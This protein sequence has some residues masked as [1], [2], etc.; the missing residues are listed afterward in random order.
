MKVIATVLFLFSLAGSASAQLKI[1]TNYALMVNDTAFR[2]DSFVFFSDP[3][4][5][6]VKEIATGKNCAIVSA[7]WTFIISGNV[8]HDTKA[9]DIK[10]HLNLVKPKDRIF[11]EKIK[12]GPGCFIPP[13][14][15]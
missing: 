4:N 12:L 11:I 15:I 7:E 2:N 10:M 14:Q 5:I 9:S 3:E 13:K 6:A 1:D 8:F